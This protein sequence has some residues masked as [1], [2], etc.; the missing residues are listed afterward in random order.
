MHE[1]A[2]RIEVGKVREP[3]EIAA[4][5]GILLFPQVSCQ[6]VAIS[7][8]ADTSICHFTG[9][10]LNEERFGQ[11]LIR[12]DPADAIPVQNL[13]RLSLAYAE[14]DTELSAGLRL[15]REILDCINSVA[16]LKTETDRISA[17]WRTAGGGLPEFGRLRM[18]QKQSDLA[19]APFDHCTETPFAGRPGST[20]GV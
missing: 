3:H 5:G 13:L 6:R 4:P 20:C 14:R 19:K 7:S 15:L 16:A 10:P 9:G 17:V 1:G 11:L 12:S 18:L 8:S 2:I